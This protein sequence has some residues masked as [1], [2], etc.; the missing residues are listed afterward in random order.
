MKK[1]KKMIILFI[2]PA[3]ITFLIMYIYPV[4]RTVIM[5]FFSVESVTAEMDQWSFNGLGNY[6]A[7]WST[8]VFVT[9]MLNILKIWV[10]GGVIVLTISLLLAVILTSGVRG[11][12]FFRAVIY[13]PNVISAVALATMWIQYIF[14]KRYGLLHNMGEAL[15]IKALAKMNWL[16]SD[17]KFWAMLIAFCFGAIGYYMLI[18]LSGIER[19]PQDFYEAATIDGASKF[20]QFTSITMPLLKGVFKTNLTFWSINTISFYI[21]SQMF[22]PVNT[23][24]S[25]IV[26]VQY[27][28]NIVF[29]AKGITQRDAGRGAAIGVTLALFV[30]VAFFVFNKLIKEEDVEY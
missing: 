13:L 19:I 24:A 17:M 20:R 2:T 1:N 15:G 30:I 16:S 18:F 11:K 5:S 21:W 8:K 10:V 23:E 9:S 12:S 4:I 29:G 28:I 27:M 14:S 3:L 26:P 7:L 25:T 22:S 6:T